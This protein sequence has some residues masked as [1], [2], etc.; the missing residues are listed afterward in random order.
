M[1]RSWTVGRKIA[2]GFAAVVALTMAVAA[3][4]SIGMRRVIA[5]EERLLTYHA[6][7]LR[8]AQTLQTNFE[9]KIAEV[10]GYFFARDDRLLGLMREARGEFLA[11]VARIDKLVSSEDGK[12]RLA[13]I[14]KAE[15]EHQQGLDRAI[16]ML[17]ERQSAD[18]VARIMRDELVPM[19]DQ[20]HKRIAEFVQLE[21]R[22]L[23]EAQAEAAR[24]AALAQS[25]ALA[26]TLATVALAVAI[27]VLL[28]RSI[29]RGVGGAVQHVQG[30]STE[31]RT[32][33]TQQ[34]TGTKQQSGAMTEIAT[35]IN[36]LLATSRQIAESAKRV[37][38]IAEK[39]AT[40]SRSGEASVAAAVDTVTSIKRQVDGVVS[41][42]LDLG[43]RSQQ[44]G[45]VLDIINELAEQTNILAINATI[46]AAGATESGRR[47]AVVADEIRK[48]A[49]RV[50]GSTKEIRALVDEIRA[51]VNITVMATESGSKAVD[52]GT[53]E[54][55]R[56]AEAFKEIV[57]LVGTTT[58]AAREIE[59][60]TKQQATA[61]EQVNVAITDV[62]QTTRETEASSAQMLQTAS[63]LNAL[64]T[65]LMRLVQAPTSA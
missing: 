36:E 1:A 46:E 12:L 62:A 11:G 39:T 16:A 26:T 24:H 59:L 19:R 34:A 60:S 49:D 10:R 35:T 57:V 43:K 28:G 48:L 61:V 40:S 31:L 5:E 23:E 52:A 64:A 21:N 25:L 15:A 32:A 30:S 42:M 51:A 56:V 6:E 55:G 54:F 27:A 18:V 17:K 7:K 45:G 58:D 47:F 50:S 38:A 13:E 33:A 65:D 14:V 3:I 37:T 22:L 41:H 63:Q 9:R 53:R 4:G 29:S 20:E 8:E 2:V 44:I